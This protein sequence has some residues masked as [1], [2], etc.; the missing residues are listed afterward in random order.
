VL[1]V[2]AYTGHGVSQRAPADAATTADD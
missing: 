2:M 1:F